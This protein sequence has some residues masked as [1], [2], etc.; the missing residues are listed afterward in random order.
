MPNLKECLQWIYK[1]Y[2]VIE[3]LPSIIDRLKYDGISYYLRA[4]YSF[5]HF[6]GCVCVCV[7]TRVPETHMEVRDNLQEPA[8]LRSCEF[9]DQT[10]IIKLPAS[11]PTQGVERMHQRLSPLGNRTLQEARVYT[12]LQRTHTNMLW[13]EKYMNPTVKVTQ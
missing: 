8:I 6:P 5:L 9:R 13:E 4:Y 10:Q 2:D 11:A 7:P 1:N 12:W 3:E